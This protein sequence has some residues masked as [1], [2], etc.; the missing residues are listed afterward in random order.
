MFKEKRVCPLYRR[1][2]GSVNTVKFT[3]D[4][5]AINQGELVMKDVTAS[6]VIAWTSGNPIVGIAKESSANGATKAIEIDLIHLG[7]AM[8][9]DVTS[10]TPA[11]GDYKTC[12]GIKTGAAVGTSSNFD[13][14]YVYIG[15][16]TEVKVWPKLVEDSQ[17]SN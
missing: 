3:A 12:D 14:T 1:A 8:I 13:F 15:S 4:T 7:E 5:T 11:S 17:N 10:G 9:T 6:E 16:T 2:E